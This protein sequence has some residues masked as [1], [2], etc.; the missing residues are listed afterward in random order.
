[1]SDDL[2]ISYKDAFDEACKVIG[3]LTMEKHFLEKRALFPADEE[4]N[5]A[6]KDAE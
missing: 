3:R 6:V 2:S 5:E 4:T 1:M